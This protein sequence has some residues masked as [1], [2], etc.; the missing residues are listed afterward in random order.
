MIILL[1]AILKFA[2]FLAFVAALAL[3]MGA[4]FSTLSHAGRSVLLRLMPLP[5]GA[6]AGAEA[7]ECKADL[8]RGQRETDNILAQNHGSCGESQGST[9]SWGGGCDSGGDGGGGGGG[10]GD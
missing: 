10:G 1:L 9:G 5:Q 3:F 6:I 7:S 8:A 4:A 2:L